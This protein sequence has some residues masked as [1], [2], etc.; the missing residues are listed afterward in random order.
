MNT[1]E[2]VI[3][4]LAA[5][6]DGDDLYQHQVTVCRAALNDAPNPDTDAA[7]EALHQ[8]I[9]KGDFQGRHNWFHGVRHLVKDSHGYIHWRDRIVEHYSFGDRSDEERAAAL[10][11]GN[12]CQM[13]EAKDLPVNSRTVINSETFADAPKGT[14][15]LAALTSYYCFYDDAQGKPEGVILG[16][17]DHA[18][19]AVEVHDATTTLRYAEADDLSFGTY[20]MFHTLQD[21]GYKPCSPKDRSYAGIV[22]MFTDL[23]LSPSQVDGIINLGCPQIEE[24][25]SA[26]RG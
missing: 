16:L 10:E 20:K 26:E 14:P 8:L 3:A 9:D 5:T 13:L 17:P 4:I 1:Q 22:G 7:V 19:V 25:S 6:H 21:E 2:K 11:L 12:T 18:A 15:W 24:V 23:G